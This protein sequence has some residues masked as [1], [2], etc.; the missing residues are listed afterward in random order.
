MKKIFLTLSFVIAVFFG[1]S[2]AGSFPPFINYQAVLRDANNQVFAPGTPGTLRFK[3]YDSLNASGPVYVEDHNFTTNSASMINL[4]IGTGTVVA[5]NIQN[6]AWT[7]GK[8]SYEVY[9]NGGSS[10]ISPIQQFASVPYAVYALS[11]GNSNGL[12]NGSNNQTLYW[13]GTQSKWIPT[14]NLSNDGNNVGIG[15]AASVG[16]NKLSVLSLNPG[17]SSAFVAV[18]GNAGPRDAAVRGV[19][20]GLVA[21]NSNTNV[22]RSFSNIYGG[23]FIGNNNG[24]GFGIGVSG[25]GSSSLGLGTAIG[26]SGIATGPSSSTLIGIY[27]SVS[28]TSL[29]NTTYAAVFDKGMV[30]F[31]DD[32]IFPTTTATAGAIFT[33][34][35]QK[36]GYWANASASAPPAFTSVGIGTITAAAYPNYVLNIPSPSLAIFGNSISIAQGTVVSTKTISVLSGTGTVGFLPLYSGSSSF[37]ISNIFRSLTNQI[38]IN[39][40]GPNTFFHIVKPL[41]PDTVLVESPNSASMSYALKN[42]V[43][44]FGMTLNN[45]TFKIH[46]NVTDRLVISGSNVGIGSGSPTVPLHVRNTTSTVGLQVDG[47]DPSWSGIYNNATTGTGQPM[48]GYLRQGAFKGAHYINT[49]NDWILE[50]NGFQRI[51][52][53]A[54]NGNV[55]IGTV[56]PSQKL[57]VSGNVAIPASNDYTYLAPKTNYINVSPAA[58]IRAGTATGIPIYSTA[59]N[60]VYLDGTPPSVIGYFVANVNIP[61]NAT[62][63]AISAYIDDPATG[64]NDYVT[65]DFNQV[66]NSTGL[67]TTM[68]TC[69]STPAGTTT[70]FQQF[71]SAGSVAINNN[72]NTYV[73]TVTMGNNV[74]NQFKLR[75]IKITYTVSKAD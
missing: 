1:F 59:G 29:G 75:N 71:S 33:L 64:A 68:L 24:T 46:D 53:L 2:Q 8:V 52:V 4:K 41:G 62:V 63:T 15:I 56:S 23:D 36:K 34:D 57:E 55:G 74:T 13:D 61:N 50:L 54:T 16:K 19:A 27:G 38:G 70:G 6:I 25:I 9:L 69:G 51:A 3:L 28:T 45:T 47:N 26:V 58:L 10:P 21:F 66:V 39:T 30:A 37:S 11:S 17:D 35:A 5:G 20:N 18:R 44:R 22:P 12:Q 40:S 73:L 43:Q 60:Q 42:S 67:A 7:A 31:N 48:Y 72:L 32:L 14:S 49:T 65:V